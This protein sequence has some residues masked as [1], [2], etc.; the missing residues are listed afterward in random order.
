VH[1]PTTDTVLA[2]C[3]A[4]RI[5]YNPHSTHNMSHDSVCAPL[6]GFAS[7]VDA[8]VACFSNT[9][10]PRRGATRLPLHASESPVLN[11]LPLRRL[12]FG[13]AVTGCR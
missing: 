4:I 13:S 11:P 9:I 10:L 3:F 2:Q 6:A 8:R 7:V 5:Q 12:F 1:R